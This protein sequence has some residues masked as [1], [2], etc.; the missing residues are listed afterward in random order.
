VGANTT[1]YS[2][3][4]LSAG[5]RYWYR[6]RAYNADGDS[7]YSNESSATTND[8]PPSSLTVKGY[9]SGGKGK[10]ANKADLSWTRGT[11][12]LVDVWRN[13]SKIAAGVSNAGSYS[14]NIGNKGGTYTYQVCLVGTTGSANCTNTAAVSF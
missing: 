12:V 7:G 3:T 5:T 6:V 8:T 10:G 2:N 4:G 1:S 11:G 13:N 9:T 14:D